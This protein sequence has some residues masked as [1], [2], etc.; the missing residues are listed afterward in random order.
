MI[1]YS[2][3]CAADHG[4]ESWFQSSAAFDTLAEA[5]RVTCPVC[6]SHEIEKVLMAP[7]VRP[8]RKAQPPE[9]PARPLAT[10]ASELEQALQMLRRQVQENSEYVG[11][12]FAAEARKIHAGESP[13]RAIYGEARLEEARRLLEDGV[14]VAPLPFMPQRKVN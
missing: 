9:E 4:F 12:N 1:R 13:E 8:T 2:L 5:S 11:M 10:P 7:A 3:R 14:P 6:G